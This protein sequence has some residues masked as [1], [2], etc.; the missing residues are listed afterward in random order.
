MR[1]SIILPCRNE[2]RYIRA[3]LDSILASEHPRADLEV[4]VV[5]GR[6]DDATRE[7]VARYATTI[8]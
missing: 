3:C 5:D 4:L 8:T 6:S 2:E 7:V 1:V